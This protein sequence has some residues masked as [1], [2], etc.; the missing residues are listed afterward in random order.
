MDLDNI[1]VALLVLHIPLILTAV[2]LWIYIKGNP[3]PVRP[4]GPWG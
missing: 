1:I 4:K 3:R 2:G